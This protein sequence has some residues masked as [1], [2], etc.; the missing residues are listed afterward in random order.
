MRWICKNGI[1]EICIAELTKGGA[2]HALGFDLIG[3][4]I[5]SYQKVTKRDLFVFNHLKVTTLVTIAQA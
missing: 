4:V 2:E 5:T 3:D 1:H